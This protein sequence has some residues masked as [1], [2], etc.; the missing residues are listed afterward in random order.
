MHIKK[1]QFPALNP[2]IQF[3]ISLESSVFM[4]TF[5]DKHQKC[6]C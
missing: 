5:L 1:K 2:S 6:K 4:D 3:M